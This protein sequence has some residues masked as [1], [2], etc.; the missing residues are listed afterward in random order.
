MIKRCQ[1]P[2]ENPLIIAYHDNEWGVP[3]HDDVKLYEFFVLDAFQAGLNWNMIINKRE[4]L[5]KAF[6]GFNP[7]V[8]AAYD[9]PKIDALLRDTGIIRN[10][11]K[12]NAAIENARALIAVRKEFGTFDRYIWSFTGGK[13]IRNRWTD[14][15]Q[16]PS[17]SKESDKMSEDLRKR[18][19]KFVGTTICYSFMQACGMVNDHTVDCYRYNQL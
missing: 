13:P 1:W 4:N 15:R 2:N 10:K 3:L 8:V 12:I 5:R 7:I 16:I 19:F 14:I 11:A 17:S 6:D 9:Q 18:S